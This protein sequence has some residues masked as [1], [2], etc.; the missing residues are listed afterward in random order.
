MAFYPCNFDSANIVCVTATDQNDNLA[1][2]SN[3]GATSVDVGA[4]GVN[5]Y[6]TIADVLNTDVLFETFNAL[7]TP[8]IPAFPGIC[9]LFDSYA[10][11]NEN[12]FSDNLEPR[13]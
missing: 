2:F 3:Y 10:F 11:Q 12:C 7:T 8:N 5:I 1:S 13:K 9:Y 6:S 4:P